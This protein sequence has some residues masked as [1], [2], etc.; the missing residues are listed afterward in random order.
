[1]SRILVIENDEAQLETLA[2]FISAWGYSVT[3]S[4]TVVGAMGAIHREE[5][6]LALIDL[7]LPDTPGMEALKM[8]RETENLQEIPVFMMSEEI[9]PEVR[10]VV[11]SNGANDLLIKPIDQGELSMKIQQS[12]ELSRYKK[13]ISAL[14]KKLEKDKK[15]LLRYFS[16]DLV[17]K[18]LNEEIS[19]EL[20]GTIVNASIMFFDIRGST[21]LAEKIGPQEYAAA[22]SEIFSDLMNIIFNHS[23]SVNELLGDGIL[24]TFGCPFPKTDDASNAMKTAIAMQEHIAAVNEGRK[25]AGRDEI[26]FGIGIATGKIFAGN[27]GSI[28]MMKYAVMGDPV[29]TAARIQDLTKEFPYQIIVDQATRDHAASSIQFT[30][31]PQTNLRG[32]SENVKLFGISNG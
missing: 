28:R 3:K 25:M 13:E 11:M 26:R 18:I 22:I 20:G 7:L 16:E 14:N 4:R 24:A 10:I 32:K 5:V 19:N 21:S 23:G 30:E 12:L 1:M 27:I 15:S 9:S 6:D 31:L 2:Q 17:Q 29:N 8:I